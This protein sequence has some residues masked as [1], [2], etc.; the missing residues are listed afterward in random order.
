MT[1]TTERAAI[2]KAAWSSTIST[3]DH[4]VSHVHILAAAPVPSGH[5]LTARR[6]PGVA[7]PP[8][9]ASAA[10]SWDGQ[11][12]E[13][14]LHPAVDVGLLGQGQ[15]GEDRVDVLLDGP[16]G[17]HQRGRHGRVV[18]SLGHLREDLGLAGGEDGAAGESAGSDRA[19]TRAS[20][21]SGSITEPPAA[22]SRMAPAELADVGD[23][24]LQEVGAALGPAVEEGQRV[25]RLGVLAEHHHA[26]VGMALGA[27]PSAARIP[28]SVPSGACGCRSPPRRGPGRRRWRSASRSPRRPP[29]PR[30]RAR[31]RRG[32]GP[33]RGRGSCP[34]PA[35][36]ERPWP[37]C[38]AEA[39]PDHRRGM[40][41][42][43]SGQGHDVTEAGRSTTMP[44]AAPS[45]ATAPPAR[46]ATTASMSS[47][48]RGGSWWKSSSRAA[49]ARAARCAA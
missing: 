7:A 36:P 21:T 10:Q 22:T 16:L 37:H 15:L 49:P 23:P 24:F 3:V 41:P 1:P 38:R 34:R 30:G 2:G 35:R 44:S 42:A 40:S 31:C 11:E 26:H 33:P 8:A 43:G 47:S 28:S 18:L 6:P 48:R 4:L 20:T 19:A 25:G 45:T 27:A 32:C 12:E 39:W 46:E 29:R 17:E 9:E 13:H 14:R 5:R